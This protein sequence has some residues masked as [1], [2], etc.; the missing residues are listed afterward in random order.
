MTA[1]PKETAPLKL[2]C[3]ECLTRRTGKTCD[4]ADVCW[5]ET[6]ESTS[7]AWRGR[8]PGTYARFMEITPGTTNLQQGLAATC[9]DL[10]Y[11]AKPEIGR[12]I[13]VGRM[14]Q[15][16]RGRPGNAGPGGQ[17]S[18]APGVTPLARKGALGRQWAS[19]R[20]RRPDAKPGN[21]VNLTGCRAE[22][23]TTHS[24]G[25]CWRE[26]KPRGGWEGPSGKAAAANRT[27][28]IRL[29]GMRGGPGE[30]WSMRNCE[31]SPRCPERGGVG[32][33]PLQ[34]RAPR[35]YPTTF[36]VDSFPIA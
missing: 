21:G 17:Q 2:H 9:K 27:R 19:N 35:L 15:S 33:P 8:G 6:G 11:K 4:E 1:A 16:E 32:N 18:T 22:G 13:L 10:P 31:P 28:E 3:G 14:S 30:T 20:K 26:L 7:G 24:R 12:S 36:L 29:S 25:V 34:V 23:I 5:E